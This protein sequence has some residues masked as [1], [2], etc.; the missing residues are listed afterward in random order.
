MDIIEFVKDWANRELTD[1]EIDR[2]NFLDKC[3]TEFRTPVLVSA[4]A[5]SRAFL[6]KAMGAYMNYLDDANARGVLLDG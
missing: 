6:T 5:D 4:S 3:R 2:L 1:Y